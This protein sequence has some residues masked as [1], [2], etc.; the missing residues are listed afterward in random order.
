MS[1]TITVASKFTEEEVEK[2]DYFVKQHNT[3]RSTLFH[4]LVM[5]CVNGSDEEIINSN[6]REVTVVFTDDYAYFWKNKEYRGILNG[7][8]INLYFGGE[9]KNYKIDELPIHIKE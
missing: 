5:K 4:D 6:V 1:K 2:I 8:E 7:E 3:T 9:W